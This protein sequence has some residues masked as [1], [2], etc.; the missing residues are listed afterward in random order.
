M[1]RGPLLEILRDMVGTNK[2]LSI[3]FYGKDTELEVLNVEAVEKLTSSQGIHL[4]TKANNI[5][6][7]ASHVSAAWQVRDDI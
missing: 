2:E 3:M 7:D 4:K 6:I 1:E 5:W